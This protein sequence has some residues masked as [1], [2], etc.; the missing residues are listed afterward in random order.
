MGN[1]GDHGGGGGGILKAGTQLNGVFVINSLL[2]T[3]G[4]GEVYRAQSIAAGDEVAIKVIRSDLAN[5]ETALALFRKEAS[6]LSKLSHE[7]IA[8]FFLFSVDPV[9]NRA[10]LA[11]EFVEGTSLEAL[12][13]SGK[14]VDT[15]D[16]AILARR[17]AMGLQAAHEIGIVHRDIS[18]DNIILAEGEVRKAKL[19][20][21][22]I[23][24]SVRVGSNTTVLGGSF[25]GKYNYVSPEQLG[26]FDGDVRATSDIYSLGLVLAAVLRG[27][28]LDMSGSQLEVI[29]K[30]RQPPDLTEIPTVFVPLLKRMLE[31]RP[32]DRL[33]SMAEVATWCDSL[34]KQR[35]DARQQRRDSTGTVSAVANA[36]RSTKPRRKW[37]LFAVAAVAALSVAMSYHVLPWRDWIIAQPIQPR[38]Q[39][40]A[41]M[42]ATEERDS[43]QANAPDASQVPPLSPPIDSPAQAPSHSAPP[44]PNE[45]RM[46]KSGSI[47]IATLDGSTEPFRGGR[48]SE[49]PFTVVQ[50]SDGPDLLWDTIGREV[51]SGEDAIAQNVGPQDIASVIERTAAVRDIASI[52]RPAQAVAIVPPSRRYR[53]GQRITLEIHNVEKRALVLF[54]IAGNGV[55]QFLYPIGSDP[56]IMTQSTYRLD[57]NVRE[58]FGADEIVAITAPERMLDLEQALNRLRD[59]QSSG[60]LKSVLANYLPSNARLGT[61]S[62]FTS[63]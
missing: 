40:P 58:P 62:I 18:P 55:I 53:K 31:P 27:A 47:T 37:R 17:I 7:A 38:K 54:S 44:A 45:A 29:N 4:M 57:I 13:A 34:I 39:A 42:P 63:K 43:S 16:V 20:D 19:I 3:G 22:G 32:N 12:I 35:P 48:Q 56:P 21:F 23:A 50:A 51:R 24:R 15:D 8:R 41:P 36:L 60:K 30:R 11:M 28:P 33:Q 6:A 5:K 26:L 49:Y 10:Y 25:A 9:I 2:A 59:W 14:R 46:A 52:V 1:D 61:V